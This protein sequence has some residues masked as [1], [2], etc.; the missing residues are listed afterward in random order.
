M[1]NSITVLILLILL[2]CNSSQNAKTDGT[3]LAI[4]DDSSV[5]NTVAEAARADDKNLDASYKLLQG[6]WQ[7][8]DDNKYLLIFKGRQTYDYYAGDNDSTMAEYVLSNASCDKEHS[9]YLKQNNPSAEGL[10]LLKGGDM[11]YAV[12][13][14]TDDELELTY[15]GGGRLLFFRRLK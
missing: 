15:I 5:A 7:S 11:C 9:D 2:A 1:K 3:G 12:N 10:Y 8:I 14:I 13:A 4:S 6:T